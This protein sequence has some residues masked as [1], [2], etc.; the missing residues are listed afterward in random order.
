MAELWTISDSSFDPNWLCH[1]E[2]VFMQG[3]GYLGVRCV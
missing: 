3:N 2:T 1:S